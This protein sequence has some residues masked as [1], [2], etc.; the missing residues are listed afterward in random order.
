VM[1]SMRRFYRVPNEMSK[2]MTLTGSIL[3]PSKP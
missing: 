2:V 3:L 1:Y